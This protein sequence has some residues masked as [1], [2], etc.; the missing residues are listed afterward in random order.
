MTVTQGRMR[1]AMFY[2]YSASYF[3]SVGA[4]HAAE[5]S[6]YWINRELRGY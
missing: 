5:L 6:A 4:Y 1:V 2:A 3:R